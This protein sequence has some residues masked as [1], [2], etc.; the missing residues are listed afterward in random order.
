MTHNEILHAPA[1]SSFYEEK[2]FFSLFHFSVFTFFVLFAFFKLKHTKKNYKRKKTNKILMAKLR[3]LYK[4]SV[5]VS[6]I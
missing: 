2:L 3:A 1:C 5:K 6:D 4:K